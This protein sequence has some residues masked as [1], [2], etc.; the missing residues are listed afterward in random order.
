MTISIF[1]TVGTSGHFDRLIRALEGFALDNHQAVIFAQIG[2]DAYAPKHFDFSPLLT[3]KAFEDRIRKADLVIC[4]GGFGVIGQIMKAQKP[5]IIIPRTEQDINPKRQNN[6]LSLAEEM[7][8]RHG[9]LCCPDPEAI[10]PILEGLLKTLPAKVSYGVEASDIP[11][12]IAHFLK[13][14]ELARKEL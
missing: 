11:Q 12:I 14:R 3:Q 2:E 1:V 5:M 8:R 9:I 6:Q 4:H 13:S 10:T 7:A